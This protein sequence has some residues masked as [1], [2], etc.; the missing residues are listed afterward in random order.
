[1]SFNSHVTERTP[2]EDVMF[3]EASI[4]VDL[5]FINVPQPYD[6]LVKSLVELSNVKNHQVPPYLISHSRQNGAATQA[7][8]APATTLRHGLPIPSSNVQI[9]NPLP[10]FDLPEELLYT[11]ELKAQ[12]S[13]AI[14]PDPSTTSTDTNG[15]IQRPETPEGAPAPATACAL[16]SMSF[17]TVQE[18][19]GHVRSDLH[20]YNLKQKMRGLRPV[21]ERDSVSYTHLTLPTKRIV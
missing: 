12:S 17:A 9:T 7:S 16:C 20:G 15:V 14:Q 8:A 6:Q 11:L 13:A 21:D 3:P 4:L 10:V 1:M 5:Q 18:Q 2:R 19:R